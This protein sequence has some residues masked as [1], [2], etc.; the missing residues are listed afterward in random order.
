MPTLCLAAAGGHLALKFRAHLILPSSLVLP[1]RY[2]KQPSRVAEASQV[3]ISTGPSFDA[4]TQ[5]LSPGSMPRDGTRHR[6]MSPQ[7]RRRS[8]FSQSLSHR[9]ST[10]DGT[11]DLR[12]RV[13]FF[14]STAGCRPVEANRGSAPLMEQAASRS[15]QLAASS[16]SQRS[17]ALMRPRRLGASMKARIS[18]TNGSSP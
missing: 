14:A 16:P 17:V 3:R 13:M 18:R 6:A 10:V 7:A 1:H 8:G 4:R 2:R 12:E 11:C 15:L 5:G 9:F